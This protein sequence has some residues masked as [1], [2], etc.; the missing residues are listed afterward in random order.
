MHHHKSPNPDGMNAFFFQKFHGDIGG[1]I[2]V[3]VLSILYEHPVPPKLSCTLVALFQKIRGQN[4][5]KNFDQ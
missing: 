1:D 3:V 5:F 2:S 4:E